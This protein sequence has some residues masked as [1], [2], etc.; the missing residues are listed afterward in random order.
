M[1]YN[2]EMFDPYS[3]DSL[4]KALLKVWNSD[5]LQKEYSKK[6][7]LRSKIFDWS[8]TAKQTLAVYKLALIGEK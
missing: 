6:G 1:D 7:L 5:S 3:T 8:F 2:G 4:K